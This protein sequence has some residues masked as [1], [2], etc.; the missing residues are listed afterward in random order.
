MEFIA[1]NDCMLQRWRGWV[2]NVVSLKLT[3]CEQK[4]EGM[5][6]TEVILLKEA[7]L[8]DIRQVWMGLL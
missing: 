3:L 6:E 8:A 1:G 5:S 2:H 4:S 7:V